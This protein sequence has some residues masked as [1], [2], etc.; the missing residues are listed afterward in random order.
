MH[1]QPPEYRYIALLHVERVSSS[2]QS[3]LRINWFRCLFSSV[4]QLSPYFVVVEVES[5]MGLVEKFLPKE[6]R[7][8]ALM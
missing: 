2:P 6:D 1:I 7:V 4:Y 5:I 8:A 3:I